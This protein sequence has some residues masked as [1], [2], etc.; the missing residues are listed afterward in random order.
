MPDPNEAIQTGDVVRYAPR[1]AFCDPPTTPEESVRRNLKNT[2]GLEAGM[3][4][5]VAHPHNWAGFFNVKFPGLM[6]TNTTPAIDRSNLE[7]LEGMSDAA[8]LKL[9]AGDVVIRVGTTHP[10][11]LGKHAIVRHVQD[12]DAGAWVNVEY[13]GVTGYFRYHGHQLHLAYYGS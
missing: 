10:E 11:H 12:H 9:Q 13:P 1:A 8:A 5:V 6:L 2:F 4:G 3:V 7:R